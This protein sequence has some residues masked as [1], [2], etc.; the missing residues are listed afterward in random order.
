MTFHVIIPARYGSTRFPGKP[1]FDLAGKTLIQRVHEQA[2]AS[3]A[4]TVRVATDDERIAKAVRAFGGEALMTSPSHASGTDRVQEAASKA[5]LA[6]DAVIVNVQGDEPLLPPAAI[7][8]V[9]QAL[10]DSGAEMASLCEPIEERAD[11]LNPNV[12]KAV[13]DRQGRA[14]YFSRSPIPFHYPPPGGQAPL[15]HLGIYAYR[16]RLLDQFVAWPPS[17]LEEGERLEQLR[18]LEAGVAIQ[19]AVTDFAAP[20]G[21]DTPEDAARALQYIEAQEQGKRRG[22]SG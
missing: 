2:S 5:G 20:P 8:R 19:L 21:I 10:K 9:A 22:E 11:H 7:D 14:L 3:A 17:P 16:K 13:R 12:V 15:R 4:E 6:D 1:L 18:A